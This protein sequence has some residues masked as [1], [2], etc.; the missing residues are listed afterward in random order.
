MRE[1]GAQVV[2]DIAGHLPKVVEQRGNSI[3]HVVDRDGQRV[4]FIAAAAQRNAIGEFSR[5]DRLTGA[6]DRI[7][8]PHELHAEEN[9]TQPGEHD[10]YPFDPGKRL[11]YPHAG[12]RDLT[13]VAADEQI[14]AVGNVHAA[15]EHS[16]RGAVL[17]T[18]R[19][20]NAEQ[21]LFEL[22]ELQIAF[23][24]AARGVAYQ[25]IPARQILARIFARAEPLVHDFDGLRQA[26]PA[27]AV[28]DGVDVRVDCADQRR[29]LGIVHDPIHDAEQKPGQNQKQSREQRRRAETFGL[30]YSSWAQ[31]IYIRYREPSESRRIR[32]HD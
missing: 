5:D 25:D 11:E 21:T 17:L 8:A 30:E 31:G 24:L 10:G 26:L 20:G 27:V 6:R 14:D 19:R 23:G 1:R 9:P 18:A 12:G 22:L 32:S 15:A 29:G 28:F 3:Q 2:R 7:D 13:G 4:Q 16:R